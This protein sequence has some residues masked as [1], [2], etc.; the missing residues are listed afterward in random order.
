MQYPLSQESVEYQSNQSAVLQQFVDLNLDKT[1]NFVC[2]PYG[3]LH[4]VVKDSTGR[5]SY[6]V[7]VFNDGISDWNADIDVHFNKNGKA[8]RDETWAVEMLRLGDRF[9]CLGVPMHSYRWLVQTL[10]HR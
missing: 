7:T 3:E 6:T 4:F 2:P 8:V 9:E 1:G 5:T 10:R